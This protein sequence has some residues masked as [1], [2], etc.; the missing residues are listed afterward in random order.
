MFIKKHNLFLSNRPTRTL[1]ETLALF[2]KTIGSR[3]L[4]TF[5]KRIVKNNLRK[6]G[7]VIYS[8]YENTND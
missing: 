3:I 8:D 2:A 7:H 5:L 6:K 1:K 4:P